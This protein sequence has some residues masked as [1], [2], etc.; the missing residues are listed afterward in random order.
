MK[1]ILILMMIAFSLV[2]YG[3][4]FPYTSKSNKEKML[5]EFEVA[6][7]KAEKTN[8]EKDIQVAFEKMGEIIKIAEELDK[9]SSNGDK[10]AK[11]ELDK[12][13]EVIKELNIQF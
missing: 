11:E 1:K 10:K 13:D 6:A 9:R 3:E 4:K 12:W 2:V 7:E 8:D 5:K